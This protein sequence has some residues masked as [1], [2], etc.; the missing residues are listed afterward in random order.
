LIENGAPITLALSQ[1]IAKPSQATDEH[2]YRRIARIDDRF[3]CK[4]IGSEWFAREIFVFSGSAA[5]GSV[6]GVAGGF[7]EA[8]SRFAAGDSEW[9]ASRRDG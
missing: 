6:E 1:R 8:A 3:L 9:V 5:T 7:R 4:W 2:Y